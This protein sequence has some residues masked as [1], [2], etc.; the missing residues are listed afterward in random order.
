LQTFCI[1]LRNANRL[2]AVIQPTYDKQQALGVKTRPSHCW[3]DSKTLVVGFWD[4]VVVCTITVS[5]ISEGVSSVEVKQ[6]EVLYSWKVDMYIADV[7]F[8]L[9]DEI[10]AWKEIT[11]FGMKKSAFHDVAQNECEM[12]L[13]LLEP[14][15]SN[16]FS[17]TTED[18]IEMITC[19]FGNLTAFHLSSLLCEDIY[20]LLG[21][22]EFIEA[23]PCSADDRV[24]WYLENGLLREAMQF[25][26]E[27]EAEL[28]HLDPIDVGKR[29]L[30]S[31]IKQKQFAEAAANLKVVC[32]RQK[33]LWEY[34]VSEFEQ[35]N[36][37]LQL[38]KYLPVKDPQL[39][40]E[41]YQCVLTAALHNHPVLFYNLIKVWNPDLF[42]VGA[43]T[44][45][46]LKWVVQ[47]NGAPLSEQ[48]SVAIYR[49]L[50]RLY[51]YE[52]KYDK[53]ILLHIMLNDKDVFKVIQQYQ[54]FHL[55]KDDLT[56]LMNIDANLTV[57]LLIE[58]A[59]SLPTK[60]ILAQL[61]KYPKVQIA[62]LNSL[63]ERNEGE[64]FVDLAI[65]LYADHERDLLLPFLRKTHVYDIAKALDICEKKQYV[66]EMVYLLGRSGNRKKA[67][68]L[69]VN[70]LNRIDC[71]IDFC[72]ENDDS[73][74]WDKLIEAAMKRPDHISQL[75]NTVGHYVNPLT[76]IEKIPEEI[77][78]PGLRNSIVKILHDYE[79]LVQMQY[80]CLQVLEAD[81]SQLFAKYLSRHKRAVFISSDQHCAICRTFVLQ[82]DK[83]ADS[84]PVNYDIIV[85]GCGHL[86]HARCM[87]IPHL[88]ERP[89]MESGAC[90]VCLGLHKGEK[91]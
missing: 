38:A 56:K 5:S 40:P 47:G 29:F 27:H 12:V 18:R 20:F 22:Q 85:Y 53:A 55:V 16:T 1:Y 87:Y 50:A 76:I 9:G 37:V 58:N 66:N 41:C 39:E 45:L 17:L 54:L 23:Q 84:G 74:L 3:I 46:A 30:C 25:A 67:L 60:T 32:G 36:V 52:R 13:A 73:D 4:A 19:D 6:V 31:L 10:C 72:R 49:A 90:P 61:V 21:C 77:N 48:D 42:R 75:L 63:F 64:E 81:N 7:S 79:L 70:K 2:I 44:E 62:V 24:R 33:D 57:Q 28:Q 65:R 14:E 82:R 26:N 91:S 80:D 69:L 43:I 35:N 15:D 88:D 83:P 89:I 86:I 68:D 11:V 59:E 78:I 71:A 8:T 51:L 34:Y